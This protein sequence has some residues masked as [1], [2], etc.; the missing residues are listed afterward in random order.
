MGSLLGD[1]RLECRSIGKCYPIS[2][3]V[4]IHQSE[5]QKEYVFW[6]YR[7]LENLVVTGPRRIKTGH[8]KKRDTDWFSWYFHTKTIKELGVLYHWFYKDKVKVLPKN[9]FEFLTPRAMAVW[10][11]DDGSNT[12][13]SYT[14]NTH[15]FSIPDQWRVIAF[16]KQSYDINATLI[17]DRKQFKIRIGRYE[18]CKLNT[19]IQPFIIPS[20]MYK[21]CNPRN[22]L[23]LQSRTD[24]VSMLTV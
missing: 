6:K 13:E 5:K 14:I 8:D 24:T 9:I 11:M 21:I 17:K 23:F 7:Q 12:R 20:M 4:R 10:F 15:C 19:V 1:G 3:R 16:L 18:Y 2:A 22:D